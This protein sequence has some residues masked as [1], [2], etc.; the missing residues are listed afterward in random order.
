MLWINRWSSKSSENYRIWHLKMFYQLKPFFGQR[1][2]CSWQ[3]PH[4]YFKE[5]D[6]TLKKLLVEFASNVATNHGAKTALASTTD[7]MLSKK[8][9]HESRKVNCQALQGQGRLAFHNSCFTKKKSVRCTGPGGCPIWG[10]PGKQLLCHFHSFRS[11]SPSLP[12][13]SV[14][15]Y[16]FS[17]LWWDLRLDSYNLAIKLNLFRI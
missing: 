8:D 6:E 4:F 3:H 9:K 5:E 12:A 14:N 13:Y 16:S 11:C 15:T 10:R 17:S 2:V 7:R 1:Q